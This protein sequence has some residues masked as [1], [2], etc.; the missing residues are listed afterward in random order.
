MRWVP[1]LIALVALAL[2][3]SASS[4]QAS[5]KIRR[6][7]A[8][9]LDAGGAQTCVVL[10]NGT[11]RCWGYGAHGALGYGNPNWVGDDETPGS[12]GP[13]AIGAGRNSVAIAIATG[14]EHTCALLDNG[15][16][17]CWGS[18][19]H[20]AL[21][22]GNTTTIGDDETPASVGPVDLG[23]GRKAVAITAGVAFTCALLDNG[24]VRCWG[25]RS[26]RRARIRDHE[27]R[28]RQRDSRLRRARR[29]RRRA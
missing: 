25:L 8:G 24:R 16:V 29:P 6:L 9:F 1:L 13:V 21:G 20:G 2:V 22:Y 5:S 3:P 26:R 12:V 23:A 10:T 19:E 4:E 18:G 11:V 7:P 27:R 14:N 15:A 28:G 17:R